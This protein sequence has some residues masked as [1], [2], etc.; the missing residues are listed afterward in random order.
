MADPPVFQRLGSSG[1]VHG[2]VIGK[3]PEQPVG[4]DLEAIDIVESRLRRLPRIHALACRMIYV[5]GK[6][7]D[8]AAAVL[9]CSK[10][11]FSRL[12]RDAVEW[13][14]RDYRESG[15]SGGQVRSEPVELG[16][17]PVAQCG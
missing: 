7:Q 14:G 2:W 13:L 6:S 16:S 10:S 15:S 3:E 1:D 11:Y 4:T 9:G 17:S 12:H 8:E 5:D